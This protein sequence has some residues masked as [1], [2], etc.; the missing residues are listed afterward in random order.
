MRVLAVVAALVFFPVPCSAEAFPFTPPGGF[1]QMLSAPINYV[2]IPS[3]IDTKTQEFVEVQAS[4]I[5][6][7]VGELEN[8]ARTV[9]GR[10]AIAPESLQTAGGVEICG[11][12]ASHSS[13]AAKVDGV[14]RVYESWTFIA[15]QKFYSIVYER[16]S[17]IRRNEQVI[18]A[19]QNFC[20]SYA[21]AMNAFHFRGFEPLGPPLKYH[22]AALW[23]PRSPAGSQKLLYETGTGLEN[24]PELDASYLV[25]NGLTL[26]SS[27]AV[28]HCGWTLRYEAFQA[29][30]GASG[31]I[32]EREFGRWL[33]QTS[34]LTY[35]RPAS[36]VASPAAERSL[37]TFCP[38]RES[39]VD[40]SG[41]W[42]SPQASITVNG[43]GGVLFAGCRQGAFLAHGPNLDSK[44]GKS[45]DLAGTFLSNGSEGEVRYLGTVSD[46]CG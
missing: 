35:I 40:F 31:Y 16:P 44:D 41:D 6:V 38:V 21:T 3:V 26:M 36:S 37:K 29:G 34:V 4:P 30:S 27:G 28:M 20:P 15:D 45:F 23:E 25:H 39:S 43:K 12:K 8:I 5:V 17:R 11:V 1:E 2:V 9:A 24:D 10:T 13:R 7:T 19:V 46:K 33:A 18:K 42:D 32:L 22:L 14:N